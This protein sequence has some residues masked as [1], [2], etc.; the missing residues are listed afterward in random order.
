MMSETP[1]ANLVLEW[2]ELAPGMWI[3]EP[4]PGLVRTIR[5]IG[6]GY[7]RRGFCAGPYGIHPNKAAAQEAVRTG[8][9]AELLAAFGQVLDQ[10][11]AA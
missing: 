2:S 1:P 11:A 3:A 9:E 10:R 8:L 5:L 4:V 7:R 6:I